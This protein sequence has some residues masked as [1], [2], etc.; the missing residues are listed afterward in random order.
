MRK[1][2]AELIEQQDDVK[3]RSEGVKS[4][5][6]QKHVKQNADESWIKIEQVANHHVGTTAELKSFKSDY[7]DVL[8]EKVWL[9]NLAI[10]LV[11]N[12]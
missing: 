1:K 6:D 3:A 11:L 2:I 8:Q 10:S 12:W 5:S 7:D 9:S 4:P